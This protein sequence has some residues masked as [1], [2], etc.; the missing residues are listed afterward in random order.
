MKGHA[1]LRGGLRLWLVT[2]PT[3]L[4]TESLFFIFISYLSLDQL[5]NPFKKKTRG[6]EEGR[7]GRREG[8]TEGKKD[9]DE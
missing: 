6:R 5:L 1:G 2:G 7:K 4:S 3:Y 8:E 9:N